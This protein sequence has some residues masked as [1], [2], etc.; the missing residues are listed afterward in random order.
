MALTILRLDVANPADVARR[1]PVDF[2][3]D[4]GAVYSFEPVLNNYKIL[5]TVVKQAHLDNVTPFHFALGAQAGEIPAPTPEQLAALVSAWIAHEEIAV[6][7]RPDVPAPR[8]ID[9]AAVDARVAARIA[10]GDPAP[11][12]Q[13]LAEEIEREQ[14]QR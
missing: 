13:V 1:E 12:E 14:Q 7:P 10:A 5:C 8:P 3:V 6:L 4:S 9:W 11:A 2:L